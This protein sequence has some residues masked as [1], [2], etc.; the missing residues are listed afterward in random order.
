MSEGH[1]P[2]TQ[3]LRDAHARVFAVSET[4]MRH[5]MRG[6]ARLGVMLLLDQGA[7]TMNAKLIDMAALVLRRY[8][9]RIEDPEVLE[10][11]ILQLQDRYARTSTQGLKAARAAGG[12]ALRG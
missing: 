7:Q 5:A 9:D 12:M 8:R 11:R 6:D 10:P 4:A 3:L 1:E 2:T